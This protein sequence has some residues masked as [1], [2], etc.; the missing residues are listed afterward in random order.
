MFFPAT[1]SAIYPLTAHAVSIEIAVAA[2]DQAH[3][4]FKAGQYLTLRIP[5]LDK[6]AHRSYSLSAAPYENIL[7]IG[8]K[9]V[10]QGMV[11]SWLCN[12]ARPGDRLEVMSPQ[13][14][15]IV[16]EHREPL[17]LVAFASGSGITPVLSIIKEELHR[18]PESRVRLFYGNKNAASAMYTGDL[19]A[20]SA[21]HPGRIEIN[22]IYTEQKTGQA[23]TEG[24]ID[25]GKLE[26]WKSYLFDLQKTDYFIL[27]GPGTMV[28]H[29]EESL[30]QYGIPKD[31]I[32]TEL[33][34]A[35]SQVHKT[36]EQSAA[37]PELQEGYTIRIRFEKKVLAL[38]VNSN[39]EVILDLGLKQ[40]LD[41][42]YSCKSGVCSTCQAKLL[43]GEVKMDNNYVLNEAELNQGLI[44]TCQSHPL[45]PVVEVDYDL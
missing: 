15:F 10:S 39:K 12:Q 19:E 21:N 32:L 24:R 9:K 37:L 40:K 27:C 36:P 1:I 22:H 28:S 34:S 4:K 38:K 2:E 18:H 13:G 8:V 30:I 11:S 29:L 16:P 6:S 20:L 3:F 42:P 26:Q 43:S 5:S 14:N 41:L 33:F 44:L 31:K 35:P 17:C 45:T 7:R 25:R 23:D